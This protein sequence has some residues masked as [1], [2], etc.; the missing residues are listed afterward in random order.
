[1]SE[2]DRFTLSKVVPR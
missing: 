1:M 2:S